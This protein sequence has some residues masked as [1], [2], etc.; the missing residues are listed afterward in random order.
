MEVSVETGAGLER[1]MRV[2]IPEERIS[3]E[4]NKRLQD[5]S[6]QVRIPG[7]RPGKVPMKVVNQRFGRQVRDEVLGEVIQ[8]SFFDAVTRH[9]LRPAGSPRIEPEEA[10]ADAGFSYTA[11]FDVYPEVELPAFEALRI[12]RPTCEVADENVAN[13]LET[14]RKQRTVWNTVTRAAAAEDR[15]VVDFEGFADG[16]PVDNAKASEFP[17]QLA[18]KRMIPGFE[19]ALVGVSADQEGEF[20]V[21]FP[22]DY[23]ASDLAGQEV[24]FKYKVHRVEESSLPELDDDF[25][26]AFGVSVGGIE[27]LKREVRSNMQR[28]LADALRAMIRQRTLEA[29]MEGRELELPAALVREES[30]RALERRKTELSHSGIDPENAAL[31]AS[32][33]EEEARTRVTLGL[34]LAELI[35][36]HE[37][38]PDPARVRERIESIASTYEQPDEV[39]NWYYGNRERLSDVETSVLEDQVVDWIIERA[40]VSDESIA[41]DQ[42]MNPGASAE[43]E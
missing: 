5:L 32:M 40:Q 26:K 13:M 39:V 28:E 35:K 38:K 1:H 17:V 43:S 10:E 7:F 27:A 4:V 11:T 34:V 8:S 42:L 25:A 24:T 19:E 20:P 33:F 3:T 22:E 18:G 29:L 23:H 36:E 31:D 9:K 41:F 37:L 6:R 14:L 2:Q 21:T 12:S 30:G 16:Q 15:V